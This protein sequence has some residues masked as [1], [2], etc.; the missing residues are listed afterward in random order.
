VTV[1]AV[2]GNDRFGVSGAIVDFSLTTFPDTDASLSP[3]EVITDDSG[4]ADTSLVLSKRPG[5][6]VIQATSGNLSVTLELDTLTPAGLAPTRARHL[7]A[8]YP[9]AAAIQ[10]D[11]TPFYIAAMVILAVGWLAHY[12]PWVRLPATPPPGPALRPRG[13]VAAEPQR[14]GRG[15]GRR[16]RAEWTPGRATAWLNEGLPTT[17]LPSSGEVWGPRQAPEPGGRRRTRI[18]RIPER[19]EKPG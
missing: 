8:V 4:T 11:A 3:T 13:E 1:S 15:R 16:D 5:R 17:T 19:G 14:R 2:R 6:H 12:R 7:G 9:G 18:R 10:R